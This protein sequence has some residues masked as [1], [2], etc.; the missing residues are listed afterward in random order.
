MSFQLSHVEY[1]KD[2]LLI[3]EIY[4]LIRQNLVFRNYILT[5]NEYLNLDPT[6]VDEFLDIMRDFKEQ[7]LHSCYIC[8]NLEYYILLME[9]KGEISH[10]YVEILLF[11]LDEWWHNYRCPNSNLEMQSDE[12]Y[13]AI[14]KAEESLEGVDLE[15]FI[16]CAYKNVVKNSINDAYIYARALYN[17]DDII[18]DYETGD[19]YGRNS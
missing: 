15:E 5:F 18:V 2:D 13:G 17:M 7:I 4:I 3:K 10:D 14:R 11:I 16:N 9:K 12:L 19:F 6:K 8:E 1:D